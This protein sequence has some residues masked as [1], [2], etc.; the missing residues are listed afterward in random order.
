MAGTAERLLTVLGVLQGSPGLSA[1]DLAARTGV[2]ERTI[3]NDMARLRA[4]G[5]PIEART[6][7]GGGYQLGAGGRIP[8]LLLNDDEAVAVAV[9]LGLLAQ[10][11]GV[12]EAGQAVLVKLEQ[13]LT[14]RLRRRVRAVHDSVDVGPANTATNAPAPV[15]DAELLGDLGAAI[16]AHEGLRVFHG[17]D[18]VALEL[19]PYRLVSW[20]ERWYLVA[21]QRPAG[22]F[23]VLRVDWLTVRVPGASRFRPRPLPGGDYAALVLR[24]V[25][26]SGWAVHARVVVDAPA[27]D[28]LARINPT[29]GVV[30]SLDDRHCV[31]VTGA[32][33]I[34]MVAVWIGLLGLDFHVDAPPELIE[35]VRTLA[36][37]YAAATAPSKR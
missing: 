10:V 30:E 34:E 13:T 9:G 6:G 3:R 4:L 27:A 28:V 35:H 17:P 5:Y 31:L 11:P 21:R 19:D 26:S 22:D 29:V 25:A 7:R 2:G 1:A 36:R 15:V 14:D 23:R 12:S 33:T 20:Q 37:R 24:E 8:P 16:R 32:D 18:R